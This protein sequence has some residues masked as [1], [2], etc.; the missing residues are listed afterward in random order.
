MNDRYTHTAVVL[1]W[2]MALMILATFPLGLY[3]SDLPLSPYKLQLYAY[4]KWI[5]MV[6]LILLLLRLTWRV[7]HRPPAFLIGMPRWQALSA[8][9]VHWGLYGLMLAVPL[10]GWLMSSALG[11]QVVLFGVLPIPDL[12]SVDK[13]LGNTLKLVH[14]V[15]NYGL[16]SIVI[17]HVGA[18]LHH[19]FWLHD[20]I[21][22]R[23]LPNLGARK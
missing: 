11:F 12:I 7:T 8:H 13:A 19:H 2:L 21:L 10:S 6:L 18:A 14:E 20:G 1:H 15:L 23:M 4:H 5:G 16:L 22:R 17:L 9:L 3:M